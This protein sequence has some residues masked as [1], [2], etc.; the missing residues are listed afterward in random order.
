[1]NHPRTRK[2][3]AQRRIALK[4]QITRAQTKVVRKEK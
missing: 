4:T 3:R 1:L 2:A